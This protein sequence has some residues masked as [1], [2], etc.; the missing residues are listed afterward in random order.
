[1]LEQ[2]RPGYPFGFYDQSRLV[3]IIMR[4]ADQAVMEQALKAGFEKRRHSLLN[5]SKR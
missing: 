5:I 2:L 3:G 4:S 1:M